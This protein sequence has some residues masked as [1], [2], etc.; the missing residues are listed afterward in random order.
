MSPIRRLQQY[1]AQPGE[2]GGV[3]TTPSKINNAN[4]MNTTNTTRSINPPGSNDYNKNLHEVK[5]CDIK[6]TDEVQAMSKTG[7]DLD[8]LKE[9]IRGREFELA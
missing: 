9:F 4:D 6:N 8:T 1:A 5:G 7:F 3:T 2:Q